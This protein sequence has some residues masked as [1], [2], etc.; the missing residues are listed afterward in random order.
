MNLRTTL[1]ALTVVLVLTAGC[2]AQA[3]EPAGLTAAPTTSTPTPPPSPTTAPDG[4]LEQSDPALGIVFDDAPALTGVE[5]DVYD[6]VALFEKAYWSTMTTN[7][8]HPSFDVLASP[9]LRAGMEE[10][11]SGNAANSVSIGGTYRVR[12]SDVTVPDG[13]TATATVCSDYRDATFADADGPDTPE[14]AGMDVPKLY[15]YSLRELGGHWEV[16]TAER[17]GTC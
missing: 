10:M 3:T 11:A 5:A 8:V 1:P 14:Q 15:T 12:I 2:T 9:D 6:T 13:A 4:I 7:E 16:A 17:A